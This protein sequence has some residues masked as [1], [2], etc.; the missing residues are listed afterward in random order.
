M[1]ARCTPLTLDAVLADPVTQAVM[2]ADRVKPAALRT[3]LRSV[4][5]DAAGCAVQN[6]NTGKESAR[7]RFNIDSAATFIPTIDRQKGRTPARGAACSAFHS[8]FCGA[9]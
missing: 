1:T 2:K 8:H 9:V 3:M 6:G 5:L 4:V 7:T